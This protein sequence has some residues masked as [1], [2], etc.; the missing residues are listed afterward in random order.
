MKIKGDRITVKLVAGEALSEGDVVYLSAANTVSKA[1]DANA[2]KVIGVADAAASSGDEVDV[3]IYGV[4]S[5][6]ADGA[7]AVGDRVIAAATAGRV[8]TEN[9]LPT[10]THTQA[11]LAIASVTALSNDLGHDGSGGLQSTGSTTPITTPDTDATSAGEH[12][13]VLGKALSAAAAAGDSINVLVC[14]A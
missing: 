11:D 5:V 10:H 7:V 2:A 14:L 6:V 13:R 3:V 4:K 8:K 12:G 9:T 1:T